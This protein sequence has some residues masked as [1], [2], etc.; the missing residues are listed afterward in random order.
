LAQGA[1]LNLYNHPFV[2]NYLGLGKKDLSWNQRNA[3]YSCNEVIPGIDIAKAIKYIFI[4]A[5]YIL[6]LISSQFFNR[7]ESFIIL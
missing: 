5:D 4:H 6:M 1:S 3:F 2:K 7:F